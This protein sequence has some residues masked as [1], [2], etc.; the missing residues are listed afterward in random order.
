MLE[1][2][3]RTEC[4]VV[5]VCLKKPLNDLIYPIGG[6]TAYAYRT[7][8]MQKNRGDLSTGLVRWRREERD[9]RIE[10]Y[11]DKRKGLGPPKRAFGIKT[12]ENLEEFARNFASEICIGHNMY[13]TAG[14]NRN[15]EEIL[16]DAQP[17]L[18]QATETYQNFSIAFNGNICNYGYLRRKMIEERP[19]ICFRSSKD[20]ELI[21]ILISDELKKIGKS[22]SDKDF[23]SLF[24]NISKKL[25]GG[26]SII[27]LDAEGTLICARDPIGYRPLCFGHSEDLFI[28]ASESCAL[29][30]IFYASKKPSKILFVE[31]GE[32]IIFRGEKHLHEL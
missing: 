11:L 25:E 21:A 6:A 5:G 18:V 2:E 20:T 27:Y 30:K 8:H 32:L 22:P 14:E 7:L 24:S 10:S 29:D 26:Y 28:A 15:V 13:S 3:I 19:N 1:D 4:G 9:G 12:K 16:R 31:P 23:V 17:F